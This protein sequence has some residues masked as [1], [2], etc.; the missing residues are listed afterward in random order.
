MLPLLLMISHPLFCIRLLGLK[1]CLSGH[2]GSDSRVGQGCISYGQRQLL[3]RAAIAVVGADDA[4]NK[5]M[6]HHIDILKVTEADALY[7][8][9]NMQRFE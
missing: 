9:Q 7:A 4:L 2:G 1:G 3:L 5:L 8:V 6:P